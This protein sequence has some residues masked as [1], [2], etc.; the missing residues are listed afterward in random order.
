MDINYEQEPNEIKWSFIDYQLKILQNLIIGGN[1]LLLYG[2][3][4]SGKTTLMFDI[5]REK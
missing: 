1:D 3:A 5:F 4:G 2:I